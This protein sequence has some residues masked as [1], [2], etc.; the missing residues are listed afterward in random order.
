M[1]SLRWI[2]ESPAYWDASKARIVGGAPPGVF[3]S[4]YRALTEGRIVSDD[5]WRVEDEGRVVGYGW[6]DV[7]W[8]D[9]EI[10]LAVAPDAH[11]RGVGAFILDRLDDEART[12]GLGYL[13]NLVRT[14]HPHAAE[15]TRW[16]EKHGFQPEED[17]RL[18][19]AVKRA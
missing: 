11:G 4:R 2:H 14:T 16:L 18:L 13:Y 3:D 12:R 15:V 7:V 10:L 8:G 5:W 1:M 19:R 17:G 6:L 9:A